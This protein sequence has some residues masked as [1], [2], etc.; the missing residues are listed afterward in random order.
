VAAPA[1]LVDSNILL[2]ASASLRKPPRNS[3]CLGGAGASA[4][5]SEQ[6]PDFFPPRSPLPLSP[7]PN[8]FSA[9]PLRLWVSALNR[10]PQNPRSPQ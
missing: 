7:S 3:D 10:I 5:Q 2:R 8:V 9:L 1:H 4:C 6:S